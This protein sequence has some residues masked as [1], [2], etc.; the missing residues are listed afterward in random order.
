[1]RKHHSRF[2]A[3]PFAANSVVSLEGVTQNMIECN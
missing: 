3:L 2:W 1:M